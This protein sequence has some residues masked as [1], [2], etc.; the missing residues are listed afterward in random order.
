MENN[1]RIDLTEGPILKTLVRLAVPVTVSMVMF[2]VYLMVDLYF[3]G[4]LGPD[5]VAAVSI[6]GNAFFIHLG[7][8]T[9]LGTGGMALIAQAFGRKEYDYAATVFKQCILLALIVGV[10]EAATGLMIAPAYIKYFGGSGKSLE[11]G[12][13][14]FQIF[15]ISFLFMILLYT[16]GN[17]YRGMG[18]TKTPMII[19][20]QANLMNILLDPIL[21]FGWLG[22]PAMGVRGAALASVISQIYALTIY[23]YLIFIKGSHIDLKGTWQLN[24]SIIRKS[25]FIG[26]PSGLNHFLLAANLLISFRVISDYGT[27]ALAAIGIGFRILQAIYI[28]VIAV[29]SA[30][31]AIVGQNFGANKFNRISGTFARAWLISIMFMVCCTAICQAFPGYLI[32]LFSNDPAVIRFGTTYLKIFSLGFVMVGTIMI[33]SA[34]FQGLGKTYPSLAGAALD[35]ALFAGL[36]FTLPVYFSWGIQSIWWIKLTTAVIETAVIAVWL[37]CELQR[38]RLRIIGS[39]QPE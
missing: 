16:I 20:L 1:S 18:N 23:G 17:C 9:I 11:W 32:G 31:A 38:T 29:G 26:I 34:V 12:I 21:I 6:S 19:M 35:N 27:A 33:T 2:T 37:K 4:R 39:L 14:Y 22:L 25:L 28:P 5:A 3:V 24:F 7:F 15:V 30:M 8:S 13:Q 10:F 36:V